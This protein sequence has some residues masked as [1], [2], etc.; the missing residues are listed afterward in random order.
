MN[1]NPIGV[2]IVLVIV[3]AGGWYLFSRT[4][5]KEPAPEG[6]ATSQTPTVDDTAPETV[7]ENAAV[8]G[9]TVTYTDQG[10][11]PASITIPAGATVTFMNQSAKNMWVASAMHPEHTVYSGTSLA[12]H[13]PDTTGTAFDE[14][15][16]GVPGSSFSFTFNKEG[17]WKYHDHIDSTKFGTVVAAAATIP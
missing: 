4:P 7:A 9:V 6:T 1:R 5:T 2:I 12:Q 8:S 11:S 3:V 16:A 13:C 17:S 14:C 15:A 10:F